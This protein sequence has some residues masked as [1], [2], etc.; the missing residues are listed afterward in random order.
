M[1]N[2]FQ[3]R[4]CKTKNF[5]IFITPNSLAERH[6]DKI[7][8]KEEDLVN[9]LEGYLKIKN[10]SKI[11]LYLYPSLTLKK[12]ELGGKSP[13]F[14]RYEGKKVAYVYNQKYPYIAT[15]HEE[16]HILCFEWDK[17]SSFI[18]NQYIISTASFYEGLAMHTQS[19]FFNKYFDRYSLNA[20]PPKGQTLHEAIKPDIESNSAPPIRDILMYDGY[21][22]KLKNGAQLGSIVDFLIVVYGID[23]FKKLFITLSEKKTKEE[24]SL[25]FKNVYGKTIQH[26]DQEWRNYVL[27]SKH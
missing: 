15:F 23:T 9:K 27:D 8:N 5:N 18:E 25:I 24:N 2:T 7:Q 21:C 11:N 10:S 14:A 16:T 19:K 3:W 13:G 4:R 26:L 1:R 17:P 22:N 20:K 6:V 12:K